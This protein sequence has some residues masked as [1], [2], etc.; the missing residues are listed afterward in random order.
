MSWTDKFKPGDVFFLDGQEVEIVSFSDMH[1]EGLP[2]DFGGLGTLPVVTYRAR[3]TKERM[4]IMLAATFDTKATRSLYVVS[5]AMSH[6]DA[7]RVT[8]SAVK[9]AMPSLSSG[10]PISNADY[11]A[12]VSP[13]AAALADSYLSLQYP[14]VKGDEPPPGYR[15]LF[16]GF[17]R[18]VALV[19]M[20]SSADRKSKKA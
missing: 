16:V 3:G 11:S 19:L 4:N 8:L 14:G 5:L 1:R 7:M 15:D 20:M 13:M 10:E 2:G 18:H 17:A 9:N 6:E 12:N